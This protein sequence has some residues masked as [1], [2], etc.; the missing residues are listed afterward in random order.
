VLL[1]WLLDRGDI[2]MIGRM[3]GLIVWSTRDTEPAENTRIVGAGWEEKHDTLQRANTSFNQ[4]V[5]LN[6][7]VI[8]LCA[9]FLHDFA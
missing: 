8:E 4:Y 9:N 6:E 2:F 5:Y 3:K 1:E 7:K